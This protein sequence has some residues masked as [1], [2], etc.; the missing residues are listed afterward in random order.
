MD[1]PRLAG[2]ANVTRGQVAV[3]AGV[4][5]AA[6][7]VFMLV[8]KAL[9]GLLGWGLVP[10]AAAGYGVSLLPAYLGHRKLTF[11]SSGSKRAEVPRFLATNLV[12]FGVTLGCTHVFGTV[13]GMPALAALALTCVFVPA[14]NFVL[15][16]C[17]VFVRRHGGAAR[18]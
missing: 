12:S 11:R 8:S 3:Y 10:A 17:L 5:L 7:M 13:L 18:G 4:G 9:H 15:M 1:S 6:A 16:A 14:L 2:L